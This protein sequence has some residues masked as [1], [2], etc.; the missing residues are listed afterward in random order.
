MTAHPVAALMIA[1]AVPLSAQSA[2]P[3]LR[4]PL[5][6][7]R[8]RQALR[9]LTLCFAQTRPR[10]ARTMLSYP[11]LSGDQASVAAQIVSGHD[12]C[13]GAPEVPVAFR[14]SSVVG[15]AAEHFVQAEMARVDVRHLGSALNTA[16]PKNVSEDFALCL[17]ARDPTASL[18]LA[19]SDPGSA[20][21]TRAAGEVAAGVPY[22]SKPGE[23]FD[24]DVQA[25]RALVATA[26]YRA[27]TAASPGNN[28]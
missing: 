4:P 28:N 9:K 19:S 1:A 7:A 10:W 22:C 11:Y 8:E 12:N 3:Q 23:K 20:S 13:L 17:A 25:L 27:V 21:E 15:F 24:V 5:D 26:L 6:S 16:A 2:A 18:G 14:T